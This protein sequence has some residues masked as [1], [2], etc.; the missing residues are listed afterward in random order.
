MIE[1]WGDVGPEDFDG[2]ESWVDGGI[3]ELFDDLEM[4]EVGMDL[5]G[6]EKVRSAVDLLAELTNASEVG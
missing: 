4:D 3:A 6:G 2:T 5:I 1:N